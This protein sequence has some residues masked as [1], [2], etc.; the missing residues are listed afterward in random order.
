MVLAKLRE[1]RVRA[2]E[3]AVKDNGYWLD[4]L[5]R[6]YELGDDPQRLLDISPEL[7]R[8]TNDHVRAAAKRFLSRAQY[9]TAVLLPKR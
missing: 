9:V 1:Q 8:L 7:A 2:H 4:G 3:L 5:A 6:A